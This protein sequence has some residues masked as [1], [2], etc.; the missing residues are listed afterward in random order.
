MT[1]FLP[2][3]LKMTDGSVKCVASLADVD[4]AL[5]MQWRNTN[6][7]GYRQ[8]VRLLAA[9]KVGECRPAVAFA[10]FT[11]AARQ[12]GLLQPLKPSQALGMLDKMAQSIKMF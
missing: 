2:V 7:E 12:Q 6:T 10:A 9:A 4:A 1:E 5:K 11:A 8:A 3:T